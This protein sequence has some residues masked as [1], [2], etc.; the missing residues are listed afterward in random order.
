MAREG[1]SDF[2]QP[3]LRTLEQQI[4]QW[5]KEPGYIRSV[6]FQTAHNM[7][8]DCTVT[9][10][11]AQPE[12]YNQTYQSCSVPDAD[13]RTAFEKAVAWMRAKEEASK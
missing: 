8:I 9:S 7:M 1:L 2:A 13:C 6:R 12:Y 5:T 11:D 3:E 10:G 4:N